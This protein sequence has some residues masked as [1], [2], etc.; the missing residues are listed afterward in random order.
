TFLD[1]LHINTQKTIHQKPKYK[2]HYTFHKYIKFQNLTF[3]YPFQ[4]QTFKNINL[5]IKNNQKLPI[6]PQTP[7]PKS[8]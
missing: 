2:T 7:S 6:L 3:K 8:T 4:K 1:I 5:T